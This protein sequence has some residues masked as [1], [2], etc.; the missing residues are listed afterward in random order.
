MVN[1]NGGSFKM[2]KVKLRGSSERNTLDMNND[3]EPRI[4]NYSHDY[5]GV[6]VPNQKCQI[7]SVIEQCRLIFVFVFLFKEIISESHDCDTYSHGQTDFSSNS[8]KKN[9]KKTSAASLWLQRGSSTTTMPSNC[10]C[11]TAIV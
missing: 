5:H 2:T 1:F 11:R 8:H 10:C 4:K 6:S 3:W 7:E 9:K